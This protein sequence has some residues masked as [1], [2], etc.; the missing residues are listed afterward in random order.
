[1]VAFIATNIECSASARALA[2]SKPTLE[3]GD[4]GN[5]PVTSGIAVAIA[6]FV[7]SLAS[8]TAP[9]ELITAY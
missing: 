8:L 6:T 3:S 5:E 4:R 2:E 7:R 9:S 1:M